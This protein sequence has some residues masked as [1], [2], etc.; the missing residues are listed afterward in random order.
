MALAMVED[1]T[2]LLETY[3]IN[4][5]NLFIYLCLIN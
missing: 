5:V 2:G 4:I 1:I 3:L